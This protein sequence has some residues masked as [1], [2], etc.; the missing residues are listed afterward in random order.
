MNMQTLRSPWRRMLGFAIFFGG[1]AVLVSEIFRSLP[2]DDPRM[3]GALTG[4]A[5]AALATALG[6]LPVLLS[7][8]FSQRTYD[9]LLGFGAG[10]MLA[11]SS[12]S[13]IIPALASAKSLG[14]GAWG[15]GGIVGAGILAGALLLMLIDRMVPHEHFVKGLEG[16]QA[17]AMKRAWLF[18]LAI[19]LHNLPEGLAIGVAFAGT[20]AVAALALATGISIQDVPEGLVVALALRGVGYGRWASA[21]MG[22]LS[23]LVEPVAA[24]LG[25]AVISLSASF[26]PWGLSAAAGAMLYVISHEIIPE[27]HRAGHETFATGGLMLGFVLMML[28]DTA[29]G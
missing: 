1:A 22:V 10:V 27:S 12:F 14:A 11:A 13:L 6:T 5:M 25:V 8:Q 9:T 28:L 20:D 24:V 21:G 3:R 2:L 23:G 15:A 26:L 7:H 29:L 16:P 17:R 19:G 18:V 4:G